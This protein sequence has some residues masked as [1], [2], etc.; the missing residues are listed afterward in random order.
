[1]SGYK[2]GIVCVT[3][4]C[5]SGSSVFSSYIDYIARKEAT[6]KDNLYKYNLFDDYM[7]YMEDTKKL[8]NLFTNEK[9]TLTY[10]EKLNLKNVFSKAQ[11]NGS[12]M[13]QT[14]ISFDNRYL[15]ELGIYDSKNLSLDEN[16]LMIATRK[17]V[18]SMLAKEGLEN[19]VWTASVHYNTDN[20]HIHIA[21]VEPV[22]MRS[23]KQYIQYQKDRDGNFKYTKNPKTGKKEKIPM[24]D[25]NGKVIKKEELIGRFKESS[26]NGYGGIKSV[27]RAELDSDK[28]KSFQISR[29]MRDLIAEARREDFLQNPVYRDKLLSLYVDLKELSE[30]K[31]INKG[32]WKYGSSMMKPFRERIDE[33][34]NIYLNSLYSDEFHTLKNE[35]KIQEDK[36]SLAYGKTNDYMKNKLSDLYS[37]LGN[38][39][40]K[41]LRNFDNERYSN[42]YE[43]KQIKILLKDNPQEALGLLEKRAEKG[44]DIAQSRL[45]LLYYK[46]AIVEENKSKAFDYFTKSAN[47]SFSQYMLG[48][49]HYK[50]EVVTADSKKAFEF[51]EKSNNEYSRYMQGLI[52]YKAGDYTEAKKYLKGLDGDFAKNLLGF[53]SYKEGDFYS[54]NKLFGSIEK[55]NE[56]T[57]DMMLHSE[58]RL[59]GKSL[60]PNYNFDFDSLYYS[61]FFNVL[62]QLKRSM[63]D[64]VDEYL[65]EYEYEKLQQE[66]YNNAHEI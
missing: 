43:L 11:E 10:D 61:Q 65:A 36:Y 50:G 39:L 52:S 22:P 62:Y 38:N 41:E 55:K 17:G 35:L 51:F 26:L 46:G 13:W 42:F 29:I 24:L 48:M 19:A 59:I 2:A 45:G 40:L 58:N 8:G 18:A 64:S 20:I 53:I 28:N 44:D 3:K 60:N 54:A 15:E 33:I 57:S 27:I 30:E 16:R 23:K 1:M 14:V 6:K 34:S 56:I 32:L 66:I 49:M 47:N 5:Q 37:K 4:F 31:G 63:T 7:D 12:L 21:T 25:S 9:D